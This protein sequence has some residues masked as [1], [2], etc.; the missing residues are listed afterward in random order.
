MG[1][2]HI[3]RKTAKKM[4]ETRPILGNRLQCGLSE[5]GKKWRITDVE[6]KLGKSSMY[7]NLIGEMITDLCKTTCGLPSWFI[8]SVFYPRYRRVTL[9]RD[10][11]LTENIKNFPTS[12]LFSP[13]FNHHLKDYR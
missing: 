7:F 11:F 1:V 13:R 4:S 5:P 9:F 12:P 6:K 8:K 3:S 10:R 2:I